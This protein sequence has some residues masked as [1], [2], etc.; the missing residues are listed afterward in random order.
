MSGRAA[1]VGALV[2]LA[3]VVGGCSGEDPPASLPPSTPA[4]TPVASTTTPPST[5]A[6]PS[7]APTLPPAAQEQTPE[8]AAAFVQHWFDTLTYSWDVMQSAPL[9]NLG[10]CLTC[11]EFAK[12]IDRVVAD[13]NHLQGN[14]VTVRNLSPN[15]VLADGSSS[16]LALF[17]APAQTEVDP[18]GAVVKVIEGAVTDIQYF[19]DLE[20]VSSRWAV[21]SIRLV[22]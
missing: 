22:A 15:E 17:D 11:V 2:T 1:V 3:V 12:T 9:R 4:S 14:K 5:S 19:F 8:G 21:T 16:V 18:Q 10:E 20:W 7:G 13:G 6:V